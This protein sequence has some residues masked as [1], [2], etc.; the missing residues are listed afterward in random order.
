MSI[1]NSTDMKDN[2]RSRSISNCNIMKTFDFFYPIYK[3]PC[4]T[5]TMA[6]WSVIVTGFTESRGLRWI[7]DVNG[8]EER[9]NEQVNRRLL[10]LIIC[11]CMKSLLCMWGKLKRNILKPVIPYLCMKSLL[12]MWG[13]IKQEH[14]HTCDPLSLYEITVIYVRQAKTGKFANLG[15][16]S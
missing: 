6:E 8:Q 5:P 13:K 14:S 4:I 12:C 11:L 15:S 10:L 9:H 3:L 7:F 2:L 16:F 1:K